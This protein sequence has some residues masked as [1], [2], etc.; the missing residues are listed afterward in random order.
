MSIRAS[1]LQVVLLLATL[2]AVTGARLNAATP[3]A[4]TQQ[5]S[6]SL[7]ALPA[8]GRRLLGF[9]AAAAAQADDTAAGRRLLISTGN[10]NTCSVRPTQIQA[11]NR[12]LR[13]EV[14]VS[15]DYGGSSFSGYFRT[16]FVDCSP[17]NSS[18]CSLSSSNGQPGV[19]EVGRAGL[20]E[21][22]RQGSS[23]L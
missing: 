10:N 21:H 17:S 4:A 14:T 16:R 18:L 3:V 11:I 2:A 6:S 5:S 9:S 13:A 8:L 23:R 15:V 12:Q 7:R 19:F 20:S 1:T 22:E